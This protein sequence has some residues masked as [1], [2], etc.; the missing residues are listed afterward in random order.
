MSHVQ[1]SQ[2]Y[3]K[4]RAIL[5]ATEAAQVVDSG[6][7]TETQQ[8]TATHGDTILGI[9]STVAREHVSLDVCDLSRSN[10]PLCLA[11][12]ESMEMIS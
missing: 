8:S 4:A 2:V 1:R 11:L 7:H 12:L 6:L 9:D 5:T 10:P 3:A